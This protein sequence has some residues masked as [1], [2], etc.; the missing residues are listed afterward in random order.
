MKS[1]LFETLLSYKKKG[2]TYITSQC[3]E[4]WYTG[5]DQAVQDFHEGTTDSKPNYM[6]WLH[7]YNVDVEDFV[8]FHNDLLVFGNK[9]LEKYDWEYFEINK[10]YDDS[11]KERSKLLFNEYNFNEVRYVDCLAF[12][13]W[14]LNFEDESDLINDFYSINNLFANPGEWD[15]SFG[16]D[17]WNDSIVFNFLKPELWSDESF[18][19]ELVRSEFFSKLNK[20]LILGEIG[21]NLKKK[22]KFVQIITEMDPKLCQFL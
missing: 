17:C 8:T 11:F 16:E 6:Q 19:F 15:V 10:E 13:V 4:D 1:T 2:Y 12:A 20:I 18:I 7:E 9:R 22:E 3:A 14:N 5:Y 21:E